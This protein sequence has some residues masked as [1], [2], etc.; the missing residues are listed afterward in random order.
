MPKCPKCGC[1]FVEKA[2]KKI[3]D[4]PAK[5]KT[6]IVPGEDRTPK[7]NVSFKERMKGR[8]ELGVLINK[9]KQ[10]EISY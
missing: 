3:S 5:K 2:E 7:K 10:D 8:N 1:E 9:K 4:S 6:L